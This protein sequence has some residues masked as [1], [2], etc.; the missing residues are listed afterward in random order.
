MS[1]RKFGG[2]K[3]RFNNNI[4]TL[5]D[6]RNSDGP[7]QQDQRPGNP[8]PGRPQIRTIHDLPEERTQDGSDQGMVASP[9]RTTM[10]SM[11]GSTL[12]PEP[13]PAERAA[14]AAQQRAEQQRLR[15]AYDAP[16]AQRRIAQQAL[17]STGQPMS[18][19]GELPPQ[20]GADN[21]STAYHIRMMRQQEDEQYTQQQDS[22]MEQRRPQ[23]QEL[24]SAGRGIHENPPAD[25]RGPMP[26]RRPP[27]APS[28][29]GSLWLPA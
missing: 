13:T 24:F 9:D 11:S 27:D 5:G 4:H 20:N 3:R 7:S 6:D 25:A 14:Q 2:K 19:T 15:E 26:D 1:D 22:R 23:Q 18:G 21:W 17:Y 29:G 10:S 12:L 16:M 28:L 8:T